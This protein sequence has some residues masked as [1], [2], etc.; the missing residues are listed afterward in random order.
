M[1]D[2]QRNL[3]NL[4]N[5]L[6]IGGIEEISAQDLRDCIVS[7]S[8][9][10]GGMYAAS[11]ASVSIVTQNFW[12][13]VQNGGGTAWTAGPTMKDFDMN[14]NGQLRYLGSEK[15]NV[16]AMATITANMGSEVSR[17]IGC[18][19]AING[20]QI[21]GAEHAVDLPSDD[22]AIITVQGI[23]E[24]DTNDYLTIE[25]DNNGGTEDV[26]VDSASLTCVGHIQES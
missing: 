10:Y 15:R 2:T 17:L 4:L 11:G 18:R 8:P 14:T 25:V 12:T 9:S 20:T 5:L 7:L 21:L 16:I 24:M 23:V 22:F 26:E 1:A 3:A 13:Q 6:V 19:I